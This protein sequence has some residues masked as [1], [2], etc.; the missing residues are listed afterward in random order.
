MISPDIPDIPNTA[1]ASPASDRT[2]RPGSA[3]SRRSGF[4]QPVQRAPSAYGGEYG[5]A[6]R[7]PS[8]AASVRDAVYAQPVYDRAPSR[9]GSIAASARSAAYAAPDPVYE[10]PQPLYERS[11]SRAASVRAPSV[12]EAA[13]VSPTAVDISSMVAYNRPASRAGTSRGVEAQDFARPA[14]RATSIAPGRDYGDNAYRAPS[15][16]GIVAPPVQDGTYGAP[17]RAPSRAGSV[18]PSGRNEFGGGYADATAVPLPVSV[19]PSIAPLPPD[20]GYG[21]TSAAAGYPFPPSDNRTEYARTPGRPYDNLPNPYSPTRDMPV[22]P[23]SRAVSVAASMVASPTP[24][25]RPM[26]PLY[27]SGL[28][29][30]GR[31]VSR[32]Q[33]V[34][35]PGTNRSYY[36]PLP[37]SAWGSSVDST[38]Q[39]RPLSRAQSMRPPGSSRSNYPPLPESVGGTNWG[40]PTETV[41]GRHANGE[42]SFGAFVPPGMAARSPYYDAAPEDNEFGGVH[43]SR[44]KMSMRSQRSAFRDPNPASNEVDMAFLANGRHE[45]VLADQVHSRPVSRASSLRSAMKKTPHFGARNIEIENEVD[46]DSYR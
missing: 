18:A 4:E 5:V 39:A 15:R 23:P 17:F 20:T 31:P 21:S 33:S 40:S 25:T 26:A 16:A 38:T 34:R 37:E 28:P 45:S 32:A 7:A 29:P 9:A 41:Q 14:S 27:G 35:A 24:P 12:R 1:P 30:P 36:S 2:V 3:M 13:Y 44:S 46:P 43:R 42:S 19:A 8:R 11:A 22:R 6:A 10:P